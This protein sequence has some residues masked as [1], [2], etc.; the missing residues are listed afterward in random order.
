M[1]DEIVYKDLLRFYQPEGYTPIDPN[2]FE[3]LAPKMKKG[4]TENTEVKDTEG[5]NETDSTESTEGTSENETATEG[6]NETETANE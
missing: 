6:I 3:Y 2:D 5:T 1:S 4:V